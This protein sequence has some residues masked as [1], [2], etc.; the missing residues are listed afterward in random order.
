MCA[1]AL[2]ATSE[3]DT[4][5]HWQH[6]IHEVADAFFRLKA[7]RASE[8]EVYLSPRTFTSSPHQPYCQVLRLIGSSS[9]HTRLPSPPANEGGVVRRS[10]AVRLGASL[11]S[12]HYH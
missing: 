11:S 5:N 4:A 9:D 2:T 6:S 12:E 8:A 1:L 7:T 3:S 10:S